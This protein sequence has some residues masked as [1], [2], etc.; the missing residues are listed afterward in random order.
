MEW[1]EPDI[2]F[3]LLAQTHS[4]LGESPVWDDR[5]GVLW[6]VDIDGRRLLR[7]SPETAPGTGRADTWPT[8]EIPGFVVPTTRGQPAVGMQS[9][10]FLFDSRTETFERIATIDQPGQRFNDATV[11]GTGRLWAG[12]M[13]MGGPAAVGVLYTVDAAL[14]PKAVLSGLYTANGLAA[15]GARGRLFLSDS[16]P[17]V[18][19]IWCFD[20]PDGAPA[21]VNRRVFAAM[22]D[23]PGRPDGAPLDI[24]GNY[25]SAAVGGGQALHVFS[26]AG[27]L[28]ASP[29]VPFLDPTKPAFGGDAMDHLYLTSKAGP[30]PNGNLAVARLAGV[31]GVPSP[32][33]NID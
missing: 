13:A 24:H 22:H 11:D 2:A 26:P 19:T 28:L 17:D 31:S 18:Q 23:L 21:P 5:A 12:T 20:L 27:T 14:E 10:I 1:T 4:A 32:A 25:W 15:D 29:P 6:W 16:F 33:W 30:A 7:W 3:D 8:P 9:G